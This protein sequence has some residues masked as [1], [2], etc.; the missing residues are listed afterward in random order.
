[1]MNQ[2]NT[3]KDSF[4]YLRAV[5]DRYH[6]I[7]NHRVRVNYDKFL[8]AYSYDIDLFAG[9]NP[10]APRLQNISE[11]A[12]NTIVTDLEK[13]VLSE[14][15]PFTQESTDWQAVADT[16]IK[17]YSARLKY[18][19]LPEISGDNK[20][21]LMALNALLVPYI[22][23]DNRSQLDETMRCSTAY[24]PQTSSPTLAAETIAFVQHYICRV[25]FMA[26]NS[27]SINSE[28]DCSRGVS[29]RQIIN[30]L[31]EKLE[32]T[33]WKECGPCAYDEICFIP[34]WPF[35]SEEDHEKPSCTNASAL[36]SKRGYWGIPHGG[37][38]RPPPEH[39][40]GKRED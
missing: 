12:R 29:A 22:N 35:G 20:T 36:A 11:V 19:A 9:G 2:T 37:H 4:T 1:M 8:T 21:L 23:Y 24:L 5:T 39:D 40:G 6:D 33:T 38:R 25:L 31:I 18:L 34:I 13:L 15:N 32:W 16:I 7:G 30:H 3:P 17:R 14:P 10:S 27:C 28:P 26:L